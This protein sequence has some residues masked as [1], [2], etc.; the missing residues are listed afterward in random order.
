MDVFDLVM[1][2]E[3]VGF[4]A[5][6]DKLGARSVSPAVSI[7]KPKR[8]PYVLAC[9]ASGCGELV[10]IEMSEVVAA[11][12]SGRFQGGLISKY[13]DTIEW[14]CAECER[15]LD[16]P[17]RLSKAYFDEVINRGTGQGQKGP[18]QR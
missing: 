16:K 10:E 2:L 7:W 13:D 9:E 18:G 4:R 6:R 8:K 5:A 17:V 11:L 3:G 1:K 15:R 14:L 12:D